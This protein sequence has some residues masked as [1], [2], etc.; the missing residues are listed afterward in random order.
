MAEEETLKSY[1]AR[2]QAERAS[3]NNCSDDVAAAAF[4]SGLHVDH[5]FYS[6]IVKGDITEMKDIL[7]LAPGYIQL[8]EVH[9]GKK[10]AKEAD[11]SKTDLSKA[12]SGKGNGGS[13]TNGGG[14]K[15]AYTNSRNN[16]DNQYPFQQNVRE[17]VYSIQSK[18]FNTPINEILR[19]IKD[20]PWV[21]R[22]PP[23]PDTTRNANSPHFCSYHQANEHKT[24]NCRA[25]VYFL[26]ELLEQGYLKEYALSPEATQAANDIKNAPQSSGSGEPQIGKGAPQY[27]VVNSIHGATAIEG[28][29][30]KDRKIYV[31]RARQEPPLANFT[32]PPLPP[33]MP[34]TFT[35]EDAAGIHFPHNDALVVT[36][37][38]GNCRVSRVLIDQ[39]SSVNIMYGQTLDQMEATPEAGRAMVHHSPESLYGFDGSQAVTSGIISY[40][41]RANP[42]NIITHFYVLDVGSPHNVILGRLWIHLMRAITSTYHQL[43]RYPTPDGPADIRGD[44]GAS[45]SCAAIALKKTG[46][47]RPN[48]D[49]DDDGRP[50]SAKKAKPS[51]E[52]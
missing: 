13:N 41:V 14:K 44:Q 33:T 6:A 12:P 45:R 20:Q 40:P 27:K 42:Y 22:P 1:L 26:K 52:A 31:N 29:T 21:C 17:S 16:F 19:V 48:S 10:A 18:I 34:I 50:S 23:L 38:I 4:I 37:P 28:L 11:K 46:W 2:F 5:K 47:T 43:V 15:P 7:R 25:L 51:P 3:I 39:G 9:K 32:S 36:I 35:D 30:A 24:V 8:E 49:N